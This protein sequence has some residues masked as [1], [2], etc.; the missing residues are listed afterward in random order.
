M[1]GRVYMGGYLPRVYREGYTQGG[2]PGIYTGEVYT[3]GG[4][5]AYTTLGTHTQGDI[6]AY[7]TLGTPTLGERH[8]QTHPGYTHLRRGGLCAERLL[9]SLGKREKPLRGEPPSLP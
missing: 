2:I 3:Q 4:I 8:L 9:P 5:P 1:Y 7:T 6:P